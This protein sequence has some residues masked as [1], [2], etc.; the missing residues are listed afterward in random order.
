MSKSNPFPYIYA[1]GTPYEI[2][3]TIGEGGRENINKTIECYKK[4]F[5]D[6]SGVDWESAKAYGLTFISAIEKYDSD[7]MEEIRGIAEGS[8]FELGEIL[9][10]NVRSEIVLQGKQVLSMLDGGCTSC[11]FT[12]YRTTDGKTLL[13]QNWDWKDVAKDALII[14]EVHQVNKPNIL[15][16][17]EAGIVGKIGFNSFGVGVCLNALGSDRSWDG[18]TIPLHIALRGV[19]NSRTLS[20]AI[21]AAGR[22]PLA[23][24]A[25][26]TT[27]SD[28]GQAIAIEIGPGEIDVI[29]AE[30]GYVVHS[31]HFYGP[32]TSHIRDTGRIAFPDTYL[33][34][35]RMN[36]LVN[37]LC[38]SKIQV[39]DIK[40]ILK[41]HV[42]YPDAICRHE[43]PYEDP[44]KRIQTNF[45]IIMNLNE[46]KMEYA[47]GC[48]CC[49]EY[50]SYELKS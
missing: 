17:T 32:R 9:A 1:E 20:D 11:A 44:T 10:L 36:D 15:M 34:L 8:G 38:E 50:I 49:N 43:D 46:R 39:E 6:Y 2:G 26:F 18:E 23:C 14:A 28:S 40:N 16:V 27:A 35:G 13:A 12:P 33:R 42:G 22:T 24:C 37:E 3:F 4:M 19:L 31:N 7:I 48:P 25:N 47:P 30:K 41:D 29:Y 5:W 21:D 45:S